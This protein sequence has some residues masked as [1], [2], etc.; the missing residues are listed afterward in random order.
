MTRPNFLIIG[1]GRAGTTSLYEYLR[2]HPDVFMSPV[3]EPNFFAFADGSLPERGPGA[4]WLRRTSVTTLR[5]YEALFA[6]AGAAAATGEASPRYLR[7]PA[8]PALMRELVPGARLVAILRNPVERAYAHYLGLRRDGLEPAASFEEAL[9]DEERRLRENW[10]Q[11]GMVEAGFY[12][13]HLSRYHELFPREQVR[14]YLHEDLAA[15]PSGLLRDLFS[16]LGVD[17][18]FSPDTSGVHGR[19]GVVRNPVLRAAWER[20]ARLRESLG[21]A[22]PERAGVPLAPDTRARLLEVYRSDILALEQLIERDLSAWLRGPGS[23][24]AD[25]PAEAPDRRS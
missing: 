3:K 24:A 20:S 8:A 6:D 5:D 19:T 1:A 18:G 12:N 7:T 10:P 4:A 2:Q 23:A 22:L 16:F 25:R 17:P 13:R 11:A 9:R 21:V 14:V 15:D